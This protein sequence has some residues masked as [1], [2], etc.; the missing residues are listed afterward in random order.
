MVR[1]LEELCRVRRERIQIFRDRS[2]SLKTGLVSVGQAS[3]L[4]DVCRF[5]IYALI[6]TRRLEVRSL[7]GQRMIFFPTVFRYARAAELRLRESGK[8]AIATR[9]GLKAG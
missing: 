5:R 7:A 9:A 4:L 8:S 3:W 2:G 1:T 6:E